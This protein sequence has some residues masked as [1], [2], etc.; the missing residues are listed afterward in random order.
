MAQ[1]AV[2]GSAGRLGRKLLDVQADINRLEARFAATLREFDTSGEWKADGAVSAQAWLRYH[3][4][5]TGPAASSRVKAARRLQDLPATTD[6]FESGEISRDHVTVI[7]QGTEL[8]DGLDGSTRVDTDMVADAVAAGER[9]FVDAAREMDPTN[10]RRVATHF[11]H[12]VEPE[13]VVAAEVES[14][15]RRSLHMSESIDGR[16]HVR[17]EFDSEGGT[18]VKTA[19]D[20]LMAPG[21]V[22]D[23]RPADSVDTPPRSASRRRADSLID[24]C[25][26]ALQHGDVPAAGGVRPHLSVILDVETLEGRAGTPAAEYE[27]GVP[28]SG[29]AARRLACDAGVTRIITDAAS[30][31]LDIGRTTPTVPAYMR[32]AL[33]ARDRGCAWPGCDRPPGWTDAHHII[34]WAHGGDTSVDNLVLLCRPHH[35]K[36]HEHH[37]TAKLTA[38]GVLEVR[39]P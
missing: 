19:L 12:A 29:Q 21:D 34:H 32:R 31:P 11:R 9:I 17:G 20:A 25:N 8:T 10:L 35:T 7:V 22:D 2:V 1:G 6:A 26:A 13:I 28:L 4:R 39:P 27:S 37:W 33:V 23:G 38:D 15:S 24:L 36:V 16:F 30:R 18:I 3:G 5:M 14:V